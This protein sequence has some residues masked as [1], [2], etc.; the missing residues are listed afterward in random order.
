MSDP[1]TAVTIA[2]LIAVEAEA[3]PRTFAAEAWRKTFL[4]FGAK[5]GLAWIALLAFCAVFAPFLASSFPLLVKQND[6]W[7]SPMARQL[8]PVDVILLAMTA[9]AL[10]CF[11]SR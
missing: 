5:F 2:P 6:H 3:P 8:T 1:A 9:V 10:G 11:F 7:S 4:H